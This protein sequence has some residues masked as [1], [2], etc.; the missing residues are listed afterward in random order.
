M[1]GIDSPSSVAAAYAAATARPADSVA[2]LEF[3]VQN[4]GD[5]AL[6]QI[7]ADDVDAALLALQR[8]GKLR[9]ERNSAPVPTGQP[10]AETTLTRYAG[11]L[12][13][14]YRFAKRQRIVPRSFVAPTKGL[15]AAASPLKTEFITAAQKGAGV[16]QPLWPAISLSQAVA[17][18]H[19]ACK[20]SSTHY[21]QP[22]QHQSVGFGFGDCECIAGALES[23]FEGRWISVRPF[24]A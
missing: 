17:A 22:G 12:A 20:P 4:L 3:W 5:R 2:R 24:A 6:A 19:Q 13:G 10:L 23:V 21:R 16:R 8:R 15:E 18:R 9:P 14:V 7:T 11:E 1:I